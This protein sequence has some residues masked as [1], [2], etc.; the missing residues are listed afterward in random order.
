MPTLGAMGI[1]V[2]TPDQ[3]AQAL[4]LIVARQGDPGTA[5][6]YLGTEPEGIRA[7]LEDLDQ[8]WTQALRV[9]TD[10]GTVTGAVVVEH[11]EE[12]TGRS[13]IQ[14]PWTTDGRTW[15]RHAADLVRAAVRLTPAGVRHHELCASPRHRAMAALAEQLGWRATD[16]SIA[17]VARSTEGWPA[18]PGH[19]RPAGA[20]DL[21]ALRAL[22]EASFPD[23]YATAR[24]LLE[25]AARTTVVSVHEG[26]VQGYASGEVQPDGAGYL[27]YLAVAPERRGRGV[28]GGLLAAVGSDLLD[29]SPQGDVNLT[30]VESNAPAI[31]LYE[32]F[33]FVRD[34]EL[35][36]YRSWV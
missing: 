10:A 24:A 22:H 27:D 16:V 13:W 5:C 20:Q 6:S 21:E 33:G 30:V 1:T 23:T 17:Y 28:A 7:E 25:D 14:G 12:E 32:R 3:V 4:A 36:G 29:R 31:A 18:A 8:P 26:S 11:D 9:V 15:E 34:A 19:V 2:A 35:V